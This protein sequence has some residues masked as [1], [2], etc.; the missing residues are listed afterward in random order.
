MKRF[1][2]LALILGVT[3]TFGLVG[4]SDQSK[5][6]EEETVSTPEG[7]TTTTSETKVESS[8]SAPPAS[9]TGETAKTPP[10]H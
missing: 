6:K 10:A 3:S 7:S 2:T 5:V 1:L 4:C 8:G 9:T